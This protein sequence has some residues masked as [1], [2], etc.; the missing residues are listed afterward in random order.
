MEPAYLRSYHDQ[1]LHQ[2][3]NEARAR[4][5]S[6]DLCPRR[7]KVNRIA[8][9]LG[10]CQTGRWAVVAHAD[11]HHGEEAVISGRYGS[12]TI[13]FSHCNLL[14]VFCQNHA[15]SHSGEGAAMTPQA[16]ADS[17]LTLQKNRAH[18]INLV[19]PSHVVPQILEALPLAIEQGLRIPLI[20]N[21]GGYDSIETLKLLEGLVDIYMPDLKFTADIPAL[22]YC[23]APD[24]PAVARAAIREMHRQVGTLIVDEHNHAVRGLLVRHL[25]LPDG[26]AGTAEAMRFL[27]GEVSTDT[28]VNVMDQYHPCGHLEGFPELGRRITPQEYDAALADARAAGLRRL[29]SRARPLM[30]FWR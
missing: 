2:R 27:A 25:V 26:L 22:L 6:C 28:F 29:D 21:T 4:L 5:E 17:M 24:Y 9:E 13:F 15:I 8:G 10:V 14:C 18:N 16:L 30:L 12:G 19:S 20:Y 11:L 23:K 7:C 3:L 1:T